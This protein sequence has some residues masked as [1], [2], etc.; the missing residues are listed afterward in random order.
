LRYDY[1][2]SKVRRT[3]L[4]L[5]LRIQPGFAAY[6][7]TQLQNTR[8]F[9]IASLWGNKSPSCTL[10]VP[11]SS[12]FAQLESRFCRPLACHALFLH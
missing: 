4:R 10:A 8:N 9:T 3:D 7:A 5:T 2:F 1:R 11:L 6:S 12:G